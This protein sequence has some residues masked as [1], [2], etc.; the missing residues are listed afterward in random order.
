[1]SGRLSADDLAR[2]AKLPKAGD[3][4]IGMMIAKAQEQA[5]VSH[6]DVIDNRRM[7]RYRR[8]LNNRA[9][10]EHARVLELN[11]ARRVG[12]PVNDP[13]FCHPSEYAKD[14]PKYHSGMFRLLPIPSCETA[15]KLAVEKCGHDGRQFRSYCLTCQE[16]LGPAEIVLDARIGSVM[17]RDTM[18]MFGQ[19]S[20]HAREWF[21]H[22]VVV[23]HVGSG[24][25]IWMSTYD[26]K[27]TVA[28]GRQHE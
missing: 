5:Q 24:L 8:K 25:P 13:Y 20:D 19:A 7:T 6:V 18:A 15:A 14:P 3:S 17:I 12:D 26:P 21:N 22:A 2:I 27:A 28:F 23:E 10:A 11:I 4:L 16:D 1:M 9:K